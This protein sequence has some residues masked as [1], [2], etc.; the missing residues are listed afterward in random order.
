MPE[1]GSKTSTVPVVWADLKFFRRDPNYFLSRLVTMDETWLCHYDPE[2]KQPSMGWR[3]S[4]LPRPQKIPSAKIRWK[5][6]RLVFFFEGGEIKMASSSLIIFQR[7]RLWTRSITHLCWCNWRAFWIKNATVRSPRGSCSCTTTPRL[8]GHLQ[9][10]SN[11]PTWA[12]NVLS[13]TLFSGSGPNGQP[14]VPWTEKNWD[15]ATFRQ[16]RKSFLP[17]GP[18]WTEKLLNFF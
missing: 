11:W 2:T 7:A 9:P 12:S 3:R 17:R 8:T 5:I 13:P 1:R 16:S 4:G 14:P 6:S 18:G 15:F 10:R